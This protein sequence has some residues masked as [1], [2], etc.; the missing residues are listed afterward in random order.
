VYLLSFF[1]LGGHSLQAIQL[2][3][4]IALAT[5]IDISVKQLFLYPTIAQLANLL[6]KSAPKPIEPNH[7]TAKRK[8]LPISKGELIVSQ[9]SP[10]FQLE[11]HSLLPL[12][13]AKK[14]LPVNA[15][16]FAYF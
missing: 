7:S 6:E 3:S 12:L 9:S 15:C 14:I 13:S 10:H 2:I 5:N 8:N 11:R 4:K 1:E 16:P